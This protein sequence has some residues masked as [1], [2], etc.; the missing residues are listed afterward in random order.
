MKF[1][2]RNV[3]THF[4]KGILLLRR[5]VTRHLDQV[6]IQRSKL[7]YV[8]ALFTLYFHIPHNC[9]QK[10]EI[11]NSLTHVTL[12]F[13]TICYNKIKS[14]VLTITLVTSSKLSVL[15]MRCLFA[16]YTMPK[17]L[18]LLSNVTNAFDITQNTFH[19]YIYFL[20]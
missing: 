6:M 1:C 9:I 5:Q 19:N 2:S 8:T 7:L 11:H 15:P 4:L 17:S 14:K 16:L 12:E 18:F 3:A 20:M 13:L 10:L